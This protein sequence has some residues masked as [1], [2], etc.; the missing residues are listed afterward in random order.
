MV[1]PSGPSQ[2][3]CLKNEV[4]VDYS[5]YKKITEHEKTRLVSRLLGF[6]SLLRSEGAWPSLG[7]KL[8]EAAG[9][10]GFRPLAIGDVAEIRRQ[11]EANTTLNAPVIGFL[12]DVVDTYLENYSLA[13]KVSNA[14]RKFPELPLVHI[15][16]AI[17]LEGAASAGRVKNVYF[18]T[19]KTN[20]RWEALLFA[21]DPLCGFD[22]SRMTAPP[23]VSTNPSDLGRWDSRHDLPEALRRAI[24]FA[25]VLLLGSKGLFAPF[26]RAAQVVLPEV[27]EAYVID[28]RIQ[29]NIEF[30]R[31]TSPES[32][33]TDLIRQTGIKTGAS[34]ARVRQVWYGQERKK[35]RAVQLLLGEVVR[36]RFKVT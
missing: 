25:P 3:A 7:E 4:I 11:V 31:R 36:Q 26:W 22:W 13:A 15:F 2:S 35:S 6:I 34:L 16:R 1:R 27:I 21:S 14:R 33:L 19:I 9:P 28:N 10:L 29:M 30:H 20:P 18:K 12:Y 24:H 17:E 5:G 8:R 23:G 32:S